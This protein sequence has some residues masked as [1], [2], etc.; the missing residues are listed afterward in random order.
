MIQIWF[1][2]SD[3]DV[4]GLCDLDSEGP[5]V[6]MFWIQMLIASLFESHQLTHLEAYFCFSGSYFEFAGFMIHI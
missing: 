4:H 5:P 2:D 1:H 6:L 3:S